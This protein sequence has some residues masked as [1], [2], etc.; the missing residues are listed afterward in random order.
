MLLSFVNLM[1]MDDM[2]LM[3]PGVP[4]IGGSHWKGGVTPM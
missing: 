4:V 1:V 2:M 3:M